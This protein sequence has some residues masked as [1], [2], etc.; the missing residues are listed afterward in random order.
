MTRFQ[1][2]L[3]FLFSSPLS[4]R[5]PVDVVED[6]DI[7]TE[8]E[9]E[10]ECGDDLISS[11]TIIKPTEKRNRERQERQFS[12][13]AMATAALRRSAAICSVGT[14]EVGAG[15]CMDIGWP[16]DVQHISHVT[17][18][19]FDGFLGLPVEFQLHIP[20][21]APSAS[22]TVFGVSAESMKCSYDSRGNSVPTIL[23]S[24]QRYLYSQGGLK[25]EGIFRINAENGLE[26]LARE[27]LNKGIVPHG[28]DLHCLAGLIK[29]WFR[30]LPNGILDSLPP[31]LVMHCNAKGECSQ[32][33]EML[34]LTE[35]ALLHWVVNL[36][37]DVVEHE[38]YNKMNARNIATVFAPNMTQITDPLT[39]LIHAVQV[40]NFLNTLI[41]KILH[42][43]QQSAAEAPELHSNPKSH[44]NDDGLD[45]SEDSYV[46][47]NGEIGSLDASESDADASFR[48]FEKRSEVDECEFI[49]GRPS[50]T[51]SDSD[52]SKSGY[53]KGFLN[54]LSLRKGMQKLCRHSVFL[55][56]RSTKKTGELAV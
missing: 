37:A 9:G 4:R 45:F 20:C 49:S 21:K 6:E 51:S 7:E 19:R 24:M 1:L 15:T 47:L 52:E 43:R 50:P 28:V 38:Q 17:F 53:A 22:A 29:A 26:M 18:D 10:S 13:G 8:S 14:G 40:M 46:G 36:M 34:P 3:G 23:L 31:E 54:Q 2:H 39:A 32:L 44:R 41:M 35:A 42:E 5:A 11:P 12:I 56:S 55:L 25:V 30:E 16:S 27:E 48:S 33:I